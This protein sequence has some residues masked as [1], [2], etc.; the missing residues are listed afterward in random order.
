MNGAIY[1]SPNYTV[2]QVDLTKLDDRIK[3]YE[4]QI[5][6]WFLDPARALLPVPHSGFAM[7]HLLMGYFE[8]H[9]IYRE[10]KSSNKRSGEFFRVGFT[11]VFPRAAEVV[12]QGVSLEAV[13]KWLADVMYSDARCGLFHEWMT[14]GR[15]VVTDDPSQVMS[16]RGD[17]RGHITEVAINA[18]KFLTMI[19]T[20]FTQYV[21]KLQDASNTGLRAK[22]NAGWD[23]TRGFPE[24]GH[25]RVRKARV[26][27]AARGTSPAPTPGTPRLKP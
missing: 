25:S 16:V 13:S 14:K 12:P 1:I 6:G 10:G 22:F 9:A 18:A 24:T 27:R 21:E 3:V 7:L 26:T 4:D 8:S 23:A 19:A 5:K 11:A 2:A 20:H 17:S 15:I